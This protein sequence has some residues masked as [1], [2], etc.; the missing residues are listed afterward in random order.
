MLG[1]PWR[2]PKT[3]NG[4][5]SREVRKPVQYI[6]M[7]YVLQ[8]LYDGMYRVTIFSEYNERSD[9]VAAGRGSARECAA[10]R[11]GRQRGCGFLYSKTA[12]GTSR[13][14]DQCVFLAVME[15]K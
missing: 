10:K 14:V 8:A 5:P 3:C 11:G 4:L 13:L 12:G 7:R 2:T 15:D 1:P 9:G 6:V